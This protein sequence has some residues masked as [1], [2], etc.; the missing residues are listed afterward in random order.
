M[1]LS[2]TENVTDMNISA[3]VI[4]RHAQHQ[5]FLK[6][7]EHEH[8]LPIAPKPAGFG[9]SANGGELLF[10]ALATCYCNDI[11]REAK[12]RGLAIKSVEVEVTREFGSEGEPARNISYRSSVEANAPREEVLDTDSVAE[13]H[14]TLRRSTPIAL[15]D[16][17]VRGA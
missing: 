16:C 6:T 5:V 17:E 9:S 2:P 12:K 10:L 1:E 14:N 8:S 13:I 3:R 11:Y 4:N 7:G 15:T